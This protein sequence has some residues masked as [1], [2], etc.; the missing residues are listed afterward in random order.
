[1]WNFAYSNYYSDNV[2]TIYM[3][4]HFL[5]FA[6]EKSEKDDKKN[7]AD[8]QR[9]HR[10]KTQGENNIHFFLFPSSV[11][12]KKINRRP[13][14]MLSFIQIFDLIWEWRWKGNCVLKLKKIHWQVLPVKVA[15][16]A[17]Q[18][19]L[20]SGRHA[21]FLREILPS[22]L[23]LS[24]CPG[25]WRWQPVLGRTGAPLLLHVEQDSV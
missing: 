24:P 9:Q 13:P 3:S 8:W 19:Y 7:D 15:L 21:M 18:D 5:P 23:V 10:N 4:F 14:R 6:T 11:S 2:F 1:M 16:I 25:N 17:G 12:N 22:F 20:H